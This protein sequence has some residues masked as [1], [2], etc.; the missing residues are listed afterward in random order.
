M[1]QAAN[2]CTQRN[3]VSEDHSASSS[4]QNGTELTSDISAVNGAPYGEISPKI[5]DKTNQDIV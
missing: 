5:I 3:R 2:G 4:E 1:Q